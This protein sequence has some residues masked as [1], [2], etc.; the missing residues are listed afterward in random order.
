MRYKVIKKTEGYVEA[1]SQDEAEA[2]FDEVISGEEQDERVSEI[3][4]SW[5]SVCVDEIPL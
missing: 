5:E 1:E 2:I 3:V 4:D